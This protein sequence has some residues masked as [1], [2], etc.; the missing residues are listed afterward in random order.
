MADDMQGQLP[1][2]DPAFDGWIASLERGAW[3]A[4]W[5]GRRDRHQGSDDVPVAARGFFIEQYGTMDFIGMELD[6]LELIG[7]DPETGTFP[8]TVYANISPAPLPYR[9]EVEGDT[10][11]ISVS[12]G[13]WTRPSPAASPTTAR[14]ST[15]AGDPAPAPTKR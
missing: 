13:P 6:G 3:R 1:T 7:Y 5:S 12:Y 2:P 8:S 4:I 11:K 9:W 15:V 14:A 10:V